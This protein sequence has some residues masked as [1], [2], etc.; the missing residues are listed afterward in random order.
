MTIL[1]ELTCHTGLLA[2]T[3]GDLW[4]DG[5]VRV[6]VRVRLGFEY[7]SMI[8][9]GSEQTLNHGT[10]FIIV[11]QVRVRVSLRISYPLRH[12]PQWQENTLSYPVRVR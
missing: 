11:S 8:L 9:K 10:P 5:P 1:P 2:A 7:I 12:P 3:R 6:R 4:E